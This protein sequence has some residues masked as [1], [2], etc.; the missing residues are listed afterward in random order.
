MKKYLL[1][2]SLLFLAFGLQAQTLADMQSKYFSARNR[3]K[4]WIIS[5]GTAPGNSLP[6][7]SIKLRTGIDYIYTHEM[8]GSNGQ[9]S[10]I[11][12]SLWATNFNNIWN[13]EPIGHHGADNPLI[14]LGDYLSVLSTEYWLLKYYGKQNIEEFTATKNEIYYLLAAIDRVDGT[15]EPYFE[16]FADKAYNGFL[17]RDDISDNREDRINDYYGKKGNPNGEFQLMGWN[18]RGKITPDTSIL[19][20]DSV[21]KVIHVVYD[22][23]EIDTIWFGGNLNLN[24]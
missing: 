5:H 4:K 17:R 16:E 1:T 18:T 8:L 24:W 13:T 19:F 3:Y 9:D 14:E 22:T 2:F 23:I 7:E 15:A 21:F 12:D 10:M 11:P 20:F 6:T